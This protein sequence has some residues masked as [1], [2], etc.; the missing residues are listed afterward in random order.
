MNTH[1]ASTGK[2]CRAFPRGKLDANSASTRCLLTRAELEIALTNDLFVVEIDEKRSS[3]AHHAVEGA[4]VP[5]VDTPATVAAF[6]RRAPLGRLQISESGRTR[7]GL[8]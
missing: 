8:A 4:Q 6:A 1:G 2:Q 3:L 7:T 5:D